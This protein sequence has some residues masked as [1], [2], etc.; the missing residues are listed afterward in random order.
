MVSKRTARAGVVVPIACAL[1]LVAHAASA[2]LEPID[3]IVLN[4][5][6]P[7]TWDALATESGCILSGAYTPVDDGALGAKTDAF[8]GGLM[9]VV[10]GVTF[11]DPDGNGSHSGESLTVGPVSVHGIR[12]TRTETALSAYPTLR[13]LIKFTNTRAGAQSVP[14]Y[15]DS[16]LGSDGNEATRATSSGDLKVT[17]ADRWFVTSD[18]ATTPSDPVL[19]LANHGVG[20]VH[21]T[22]D[23]LTHG[24][25]AGCVLTRWGV[26]IPGD[27]TRYLMMFTEL[28]ATNAAAIQKAAK[29]NKQHLTAGLLTGISLKVKARILNWDLT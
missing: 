25:G 24:D 7:T 8:D 15:F 3:G 1:M 17:S 14:V 23:S 20:H 2:A 29:Y 13:S 22:S 6:G 26:R 28:R 10:D 5:A 11:A 21:S 18:D 27:S 16:N 9:M 12:I 4:G 19:T